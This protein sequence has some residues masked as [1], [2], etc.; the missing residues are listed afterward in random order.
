MTGKHTIE[1]KAVSLSVQAG[2]PT[3]LWGEPGTGKS[4]FIQ[5]LSQRLGWRL[6]TIIASLHEPSDFIGLPHFEQGVT[7]FAPP[8]F[9]V[10]LQKTQG[11]AVL[12]LDEINT[13]PPA[14]QAALMRLVL[15]RKVGELQLPSSVR[16]VAAANPT[17]ANAAAWDLL[18]PLSNRFVH[19]RWEGLPPDVWLDC[20]LSDRFDSFQ[21]P[22]LPEDW[23]KWRPYA[24]SII[25]EFL[26]RNPSLIQCIPSKPSPDSY[27]YPTRRSWYDFALPS[28]TAWKASGEG[29][30]VLYVLVSGC[31]GEKVATE[32]LNFMRSF[33]IPTVDSVL[34]GEVDF[35]KLRRDVCSVVFSTLLVY[36]R[37]HS[38]EF[39]RVVEVF[40]KAAQEGKLDVAY[41]FFEQLAHFYKEYYIKT[42]Q[43]LTY[44]SAHVKPYVEISQKL[45][46]LL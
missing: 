33:D 17:F 14:V 19:I 4:A 46:E 44:D 10:D 40:G 12:F 11:E 37:D 28:I 43:K 23:Q 31:V 5:S 45:K 35:S 38:E 8:Q 21:I 3:L 22:L 16:I 34:R 9:L 36:V 15:E 26:R 2:L 27:A 20:V 39:S 24:S 42:G 18:L 7:K 30:D 6:V 32:L 41:P 1:A 25:T 13:A 29:E